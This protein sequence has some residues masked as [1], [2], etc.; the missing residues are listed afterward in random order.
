MDDWGFAVTT[1]KLQRSLL[2]VVLRD[3]FMSY[4]FLEFVVKT[5]SVL[6]NVPIQVFFL[7]AYL[8]QILPSE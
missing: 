3:T 1:L 6:F 2:R 5:V 4:S 8:Y 7:H